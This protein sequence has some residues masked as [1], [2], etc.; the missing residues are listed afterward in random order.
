MAPKGMVVMSKATGTADVHGKPDEYVQLMQ[1]KKIFMTAF[2]LGALGCML[3]PFVNVMRQGV[4]YNGWNL[5]MNSTLTCKVKAL[6]S[7]GQAVISPFNFGMLLALLGIAGA[8]ICA[9][10]D[11]RK[12]NLLRNGCL[13]SAFF[14]AAGVIL[15]F[16]LTKIDIDSVELKMGGGVLL[17][18]LCLL[19]YVIFA[20]VD[21]P[22]P[23][24]EV[25]IYLLL[26][27]LGIVFIYPYLNT[28]ALA[29]DSS[30]ESVSV[31]PRAF[32]LN[33]IYFVLANPKFYNGVLITVSRTV[34]GTILGL[35]CTMVF[36]YG[37]SKEHLI[38]QKIYTK[39]CVFTMYFSGGLIPSFLVFRQLGLMN[40]YLVYI[41]PNLINVFNMILAVNYYKGLP[42]ALE[43]SA[44]IDG[45]S[46]F[47][48]LF[49]IILPV[50]APIVAV[51][52]LFNAV[53]QWNSWYDAYLYMTGRPDLK[54]LQNVLIDIVNES[55]IDKFLANLP[56]SIKNELTQAPIGRSIVAAAI[57]LTI[58]PIILMYP[59]LQKYFVKGMM[60]G[61]VKE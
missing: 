53:F 46:D 59:L 45:A 32:T 23:I 43:E 57:I 61:S 33:N 1:K 50:S 12:N 16:T 48:I 6:G 17:T 10:M 5:L 19:C 54:P 41:I 21:K 15:A 36:S 3:L 58:G 47:R 38:G 11:K 22:T 25:V 13:V 27:L 26:T 2:L 56:I 44:K 20:A 31:L 40:N 35:F 28:L 14:A 60:L 7:G 9:W 4:S 49:S 37:M 30:G 24:F 51:I 18:C 8:F 29:F 55:Q 52:G 34:I 39:L 42:A